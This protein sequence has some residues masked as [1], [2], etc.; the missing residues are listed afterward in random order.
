MPAIMPDAA[1][2]YG[3]APSHIE[4]TLIAPLMNSSFSAYRI[5]GFDVAIWVNKIF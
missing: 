2:D 5:I 4:Y 1:V 3:L